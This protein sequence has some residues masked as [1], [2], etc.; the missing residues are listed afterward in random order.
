M[1][2]LDTFLRLVLPRRVWRKSRVTTANRHTPRRALLGLEQLEGR[3]LLSSVPTISPI[4]KQFDIENTPLAVNFTVGDP[5]V[6]VS[7]LSITATSSNT[8]IIPN[9]GLTILGSAA[10]RTLVIAPASN[11]VGQAEITLKVQNSNGGITTEVVHVLVTSTQT[12]GFTDNFNRPD[13]VFLGVGW[14]ENVGDLAVKTNQ[15]VAR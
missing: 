5:V 14:N 15:G 12:L 1:N 4:G 10:N 7:T 3:E 6:P 13:S 2:R 9:S 8:T 11:Q